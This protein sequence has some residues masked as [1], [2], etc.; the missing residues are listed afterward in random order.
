[1]YFDPNKGLI[2]TVHGHTS[3]FLFKLFNVSCVSHQSIKLVVIY[4]INALHLMSFMECVSSRNI[5]NCT[6]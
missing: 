6:K 4:T 3:T 5:H 1:M 2:S